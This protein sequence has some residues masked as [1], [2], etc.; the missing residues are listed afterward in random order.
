MDEINAHSVMEHVTRQ[1]ASNSRLPRGSIRW[2]RH[3]VPEH[4]LRHIESL[5]RIIFTPPPMTLMQS[6]DDRIGVLHL[7]SPFHRAILH[8]VCR[9]WGASQ[10]V[11]TGGVFVKMAIML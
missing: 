3:K 10:G 11:S 6:K 2:L 1:H 4:T 9:W 5:I 7:P 8:A